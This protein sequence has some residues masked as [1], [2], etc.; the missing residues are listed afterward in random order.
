[1]IGVRYGLAL[2]Q[3]AGHGLHVI[4]AGFRP[5]PP[6]PGARAAA[7]P[8]PAGLAGA[9]ARVDTMLA[10]D[11]LPH[12]TR[13]SWDE[14]GGGGFV[15]RRDR[16]G[17]PLP[18]LDRQLVGQARMVWTLAAAHRHGLTGRGYLQLAGRGV[19]FLLERMWDPA[20]G[21]FV[22]AVAAGGAVVDGSKDVCAQAYALHAL[23]EYA[24]AARDAEALA[25]AGRHFDVLA[26]RAGDGATGYPDR[27]NRDWTPAPG[28]AGRSAGTHLHLLS[29]FGTLA[30]ASRLAAHREALDRVTD[31]LLTRAIDRRHGCAIDRLD[32]GEGA[33]RFAHGPRIT[34]YGHSAEMA[35]MLLDA[36]DRLGRPREPVRGAILGLVEH[37][38]AYGFDWRRGGLAHYGPLRGHVA[39]AV[40][41][42][43][44]RL[45]KLWWPQAE[46]VVAL[47]E[48]YRWTGDAGYWAALVRQL[49]WIGRYQADREGGD[50]WTATTWRGRPRPAPARHGKIDP[51]HHGRALMRVGRT[52][53]LLARKPVGGAPIAGPGGLR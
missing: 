8:T 53:R 50:W 42:S 7:H 10:R 15:T 17:R 28:G 24:L 13:E 9:L 18:S 51:Y 45:D 47:G 6:G 23:G 46:V 49:D 27:L 1:M 33:S 12:W 11:V 22:L 4:L 34:S 44:R 16:A 38:L 36:L 41:L 14:T 39:R 2:A 32:A 40:Y 37:A 21:G 26:R 25:A 29:A 48:A 19:R 31:L 35:W 52:L 43:P 3:R 30:E 20:H 5:R